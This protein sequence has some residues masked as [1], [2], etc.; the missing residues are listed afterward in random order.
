MKVGS[1]LDGDAPSISVADASTGRTLSNG[2]GTKEDIF[3]V[4][5]LCAPIFWC[6]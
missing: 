5:H 4:P 6:S 2:P 1:V 3:Q